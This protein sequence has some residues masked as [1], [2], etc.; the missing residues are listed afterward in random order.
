MRGWMWQATNELSPL[1]RM[2]VTL[3]HFSPHPPSCDQLAVLSGGPIG[4]VRSC[5]KEAGRKLGEAM[6]GTA[7]SVR[8]DVLASSRGSARDTEETLAAA[9]QGRFAELT[10][11]CW[12]PDVVYCAGQQ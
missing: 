1:L 7:D 11:E 3:R 9:E 2:T 5:H 8:A 12:T 4:T 6:A 10:A